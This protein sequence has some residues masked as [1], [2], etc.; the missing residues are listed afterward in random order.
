MSFGATGAAPASTCEKCGKALE[1]GARFCTG[2]GTAI[3]SRDALAVEA[4][5]AAGEELLW[6][7]MKVSLA[8]NSGIPAMPLLQKALALGLAPRDQAQAHLC[9]GEGYREIV[10]NSGIPWQKM[11]EANEFRQGILEIEK[12][13]E[14]DRAGS[15]GFFEEPLN[16]GRLKDLDHMYNMEAMA[17]EKQEG[18]DAAITFLA[19]KMRAVEHLS[20]PPLLLSLSRLAEFYKDTGAVEDARRCLH[21]ILKTEPLYPADEERNREVRGKARQMLDE[22]QRQFQQSPEAPEAFP[23][24]KRGTSMTQPSA[25]VHLKRAY[26]FIQEVDRATENFRQRAIAH[27]TQVE[28]DQPFLQGM[29]TTIK[30]NQQLKQQKTSLVNDLQLANQEIDRAVSVDREATVQTADGTFSAL[31]LRALITYMNGQIEMIW[32]KSEDAKRLLNSSLQVVELPDAHYMLGLLYESEYK[33]ADALKHF[34]R[35]LE[36]D[37][38]GELSVSALREANAMKN[39]K[40]KFRGNWLLLIVLT[41]FYIIPGV[42]YFW[43]KYK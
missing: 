8:E 24:Q 9:L 21:K 18:A 11:V 42:I 43:K 1:A 39:Y 29:V 10:G 15:L 20:R 41:L 28:S 33:P 34:E 32:G 4:P 31:Q 35:C 16:I 37:P 26:G 40:K 5:T 19:P 3:E 27:D 25:D 7:A 2:C 14:V 13:L 23:S 12:A 38:G 30:G 17:K 22:I 6:E 36:L